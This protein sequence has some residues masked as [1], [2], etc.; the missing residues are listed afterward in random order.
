MKTKTIDQ[1]KGGKWII[2]M[3]HVGALPGTPMHSKPFQ[4]IFE[5][6]V[7]ETSV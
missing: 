3:F 5:Q 6:A 4:F 7:E 1:I 2:G